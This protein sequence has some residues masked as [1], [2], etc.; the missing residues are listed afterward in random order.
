MEKT[1]NDFRKEICGGHY[2]TQPS[3]KKKCNQLNIHGYFSIRVEIY[4]THSLYKMDLIYLVVSI[5]SRYPWF[6]N[7]SLILNGTRYHDLLLWH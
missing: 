4:F 6:L 1:L 5:I 7:E 3:F 2:K